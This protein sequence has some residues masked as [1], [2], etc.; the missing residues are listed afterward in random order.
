M[1]E[2]GTTRS[3]A[4]QSSRVGIRRRCNRFSRPRSPNGQMIRAAASL[5][6]KSEIFHSTWSSSSRASN[7]SLYLARSSVWSATESSGINAKTSPP[8]SC[9]SKIPYESHKTSRRTNPGTSAATSAQSIPATELPTISAPVSPAASNKSSSDGYPIK[10]TV[11][12]PILRSRSL[13]CPAAMV[14]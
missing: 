1:Y 2:G 4:P 5:A 12:V 7:S 11:E 3:F 9:T 10:M 6:R 14:R 13:E 8:G